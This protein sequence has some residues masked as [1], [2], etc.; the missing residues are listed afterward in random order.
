MDRRGNALDSQLF[1][2]IAW[3]RAAAWFWLVIVAAASTTRMT[4]KAL[5]WAMVAVSGAVTAWMLRRTLSDASSGGDPIALSADLVTGMGLLVSDG[6]V[7]QDGRPQSLAAAWP[8]AVVLTIGVARGGVPAALTALALGLGRA[9]ALIGMSG[10][11]RSWK[12]SE[13]L[14]VL[15][16]VVLYA[17]AGT[18]MASVSR[19]LH[20]AEDEVARAMA[21]EEVARDLHDGILQTL[22][23]FQRRSDNPS[24]VHLA[25]AQEAELREY[26]FDAD[27]K[28]SDHPG[29]SASDR[30]SS[31]RSADTPSSIEGSIRHVVTN[32]IS[33]W[34]LDV[35]QAYAEPL[36][37]LDPATTKA[38]TGATRE[39]LANVAK[40]SGT[41]KANLLVE[42]DG[43]DVIVTVRDRGV[44]FDIGLVTRRG[45]NSSLA[46][47]LRSVGGHAK[48]TST[49]GRGTDIELRVPAT[50]SPR[51]ARLPGPQSRVVHA[52]TLTVTD[53]ESGQT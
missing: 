48:I 26:L 37:D 23:A 52:T 25:K 5:G 28:R 7:Y 33:R 39:C 49:H 29:G 41:T 53:N 51:R 4:D 10:N 15:S 30:D 22:A 20:L 18:A 24:L 21:R 46:E 11:P 19:K 16:T 14:S 34:N 8:V 6:W 9:M 2:G 43:T 13:L 45:L 50:V 40:H 42:S 3:F 27:K 31:G 17:F 35:D 44:G 1:V 47:P 36:P 12:M 32:V 38:L